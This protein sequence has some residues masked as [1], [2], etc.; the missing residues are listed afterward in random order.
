MVPGGIGGMGIS[1]TEQLGDLILNQDGG[2]G[3]TGIV[4]TITGFG[5]IC[6]NGVEVHF[7]QSTTITVDGQSG[8]IDQLK[9]GQTVAVN[10][11]IRGS[12]ITAKSISLRQAVS[13]TIE[14]I[15]MAR[16]QIDIL[17]QKVKFGRRTIVGSKRPGAPSRINQLRVDDIIAV[18]G[19]RAR[20]GAIIAS[21][22]DTGLNTGRKVTLT[23][24]V[25]HSSRAQFSVENVA[26]KPANL[27]IGRIRTGDEVTVSGT[28]TGTKII[29]DRAISK[30]TLSLAQKGG[31][32]LIEG[33]V[34]DIP[35]KAKKI[36]LGT[37]RVRLSKKT[38]FSGGDPGALTV[39]SRV[40]VL[41]E[42]TGRNKLTAHAV[43][44]IGDAGLDERSPESADHLSP[45]SDDEDGGEDQKSDDHS[46]SDDSSSGSGNNNSGSES[47]NNSGQ[48]SIIEN[49]GD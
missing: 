15:D 13:G 18:S 37:M 4:G 28:W 38:L 46:K 40:I 24:R 9:L 43:S 29:A 16:R 41:A 11:E 36:D 23:G 3:G 7:S 26:V 44:V 42:R 49:Q 2:V 30:P 25:S 45:L 6:V 5:S 12:R 33:Y 14:G 19:L 22:I 1:F 35:K 10:V 27:R 32:L 47:E 34:R 8:H 48:G 20:N 21:R 31:H 17:G 39:N